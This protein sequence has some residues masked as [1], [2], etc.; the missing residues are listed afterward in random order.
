MKLPEND[1]TND[2]LGV[3]LFVTVL[4]IKAIAVTAVLSF[5]LVRG[6]WAG[7]TSLTEAG[8]DTRT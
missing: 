2:M 5:R 3:L 4:I 6:A 7:L 8:Q 1:I